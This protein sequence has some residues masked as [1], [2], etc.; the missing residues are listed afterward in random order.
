MAML[1]P[2]QKIPDYLLKTITEGV[3]RDDRLLET[4]GGL[5]LLGLIGPRRR[6]PDVFYFDQNLM[7]II[8]LGLN[9]DIQPLETH[10]T[11][12]GLRLRYLLEALGIMSAYAMTGRTRRQMLQITITRLWRKMKHG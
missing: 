6:V 8:T 5:K 10:L 4:V 2:G 12:V 1:Q 3:E 11:P 9:H 7:R